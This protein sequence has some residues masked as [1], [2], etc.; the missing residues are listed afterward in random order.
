MVAFAGNSVLCRL[1]LADAAIDPA[2]FTVL[3]LVSGAVIL[4]LILYLRH[5][6]STNVVSSGSW[7]SAITL[8]VYAVFFS[9][10][11]VSLSAASGAIRR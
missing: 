9:Y 2:S 7:R 5:R 8:F 6:E 1:A 4:A 10:A 3:R 11:Y